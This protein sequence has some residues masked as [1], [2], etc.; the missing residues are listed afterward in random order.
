MKARSAERILGLFALALAGCG[1][2]GA[3]TNP[4]DA[5]AQTCVDHINELRAKLSRPAPAYARWTDGEVCAGQEA[6]MNSTS[7]KAHSAFG[8]CKENA[9]DECPGWPGPP[10]TMITQCLDL[11]WAEGPGTDFSTHG[12]YI[13]MS[14]TMY[15][16]VACGFVVLP[17]SSV[18]SA[19]FLPVKRRGRAPRAPPKALTLDAPRQ[20]RY[21]G[22]GLRGRNPLL[23]RAPRQGD[24]PRH[25][26][27]R[28]RRA[29][30]RQAGRRARVRLAGSELWA[31][32]RAFLVLAKSPGAGN[33][34]LPTLPAAVARDLPAEL[35]AAPQ[36]FRDMLMF[37]LA[38][39]DTVFGPVSGGDLRASV[40]SGELRNAAAMVVDAGIWVRATLV[41]SPRAGSA[42]P[43]VESLRAP[44][45]QGATVAERLAERPA[46]RPSA[47]SR[48]VE[49][50]VARVPRSRPITITAGAAAAV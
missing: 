18:G 25:G 20:P 26:R 35:A 39:G 36:A 47:S 12:H 40:D 24:G 22:A 6:Q 37:W 44:S 3:A 28:A 19:E 29:P 14:S 13:N 33:P 38:E 41:A 8:M 16:K 31:S 34:M 32:P 7:G 1:G 43:A 45:L 49:P 48:A 27:R 5:E 2:G 17:D 23:H 21:A 11:M 15:T 42:V 46:H 50:L 4:Y 9:Q 30:R 10:G